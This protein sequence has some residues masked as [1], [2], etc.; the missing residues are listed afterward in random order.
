MAPLIRETCRYT[1]EH[2]TGHRKIRAVRKTEIEF[3]PW[4]GIRKGYIEEAT[5]NNADLHVEDGKK[6]QPR[7]RAWARMQEQ[8]AGQSHLAEAESQPAVADHLF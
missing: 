5:W 1:N 7:S 2:N 6:L 4:G 8:R 3:R